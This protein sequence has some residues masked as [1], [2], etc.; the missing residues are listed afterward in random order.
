M[1]MLRCEQGWGLALLFI[2]TTSGCTMVEKPEC[3]WDGDGARYHKKLSQ[4]IVAPSWGEKSAYDEHQ[5][6]FINLVQQ[7]RAQGFGVTSAQLVSKDQVL[8]Y[9]GGSVTQRPLLPGLRVISAIHYKDKKQLVLAFNADITIR[10]PAKPLQLLTLIQKDNNP[11]DL[12]TYLDDT[13]D[14]TT[15]GASL[16]CQVK[17]A[18]AGNATVMNGLSVAHNP[19]AIVAKNP[20]VYHESLSATIS[21]H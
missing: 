16:T 9:S 4:A 13:K 17:D 14:C 8:T 19:H 6:G 21:S 5:R 15:A 10:G 1:G 7:M 2:M 20:G 11:T 12:A 3:K 18:P